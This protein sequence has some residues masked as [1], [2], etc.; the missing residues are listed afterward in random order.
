MSQM[1]RLRC[2]T[3]EASMCQAL[4]V[5]VYCPLALSRDRAIGLS[6]MSWR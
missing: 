1:A 5:K 6:F 2:W 4:G 3:F